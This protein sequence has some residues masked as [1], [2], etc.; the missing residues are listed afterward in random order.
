[1]S[2]AAF[3][4]DAALSQHVL[5]HDHPLRP[6]RLRLTFE[7]LDAYQAFSL[8]GSR[9]VPPR[10]ASDDEVLSF[11]TAE[12]L[13]AVKRLSRGEGGIDAG[14]Y[15]FSDHG[16]NPPYPGMYEASLLSVGASLE[17]ARLVA[18][19]EVDVAFNISGG[20][21]HAEAG[22]AS[23]FCVFNDPVIAVKYLLER[24][25]SR[26]AY[27]DIDAHHAD[28]VQHAFYSDSRVL[29]ISFHEWGRY[30]FPGTGEVG[31][32]GRG[33]GLGYA[34]NVPLAPFTTDQMYLAAFQEVVPPLLHAFE[35]QIVVSQLGVDTH[36][37]D[38]LA[39]LMLTTQGYSQVVRLIRDLAPRWLALGG[40]GYDLG[41]VA[42]SWALAYG[43]MLDREWPNEIPQDYRG[44]Y[45]INVLR[46][47]ESPTM[48][49]AILEQAERFNRDRVEEIKRLIFP[50]HGL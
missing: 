7:L 2:R 4:Y 21:H 8:P 47:G 28:G 22:R 16:D 1:M 35:P 32:M 30:L 18:D 17:A 31:E 20:L 27:I 34:V 9:L 38:P 14:R 19:G 48:E 10:L 50:L 33:E 49:A 46:D 6:S 29:T 41:V 13:E 36:I 37:L 25:L 26:V 45:S 12:Y 44:R 11:H 42:R 43:L 40:G 5:R 3:V 24:G 15:N 39:H 23:G